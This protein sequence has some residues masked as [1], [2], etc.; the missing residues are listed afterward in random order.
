MN[1]FAVVSRDFATLGWKVDISVCSFV[2]GVEMI[3]PYSHKNSFT[4]WLPMPPAAPVI[5]T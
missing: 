2:Q 4:A 3:N 1:R 5:K